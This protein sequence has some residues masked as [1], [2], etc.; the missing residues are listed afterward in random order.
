MAKAKTVAKLEKEFLAILIEKKD[1]FHRMFKED[2]MGI[3]AVVGNADLAGNMLPTGPKYKMHGMGCSVSWMEGKGIR[4]KKYAQAAGGAMM[5][6]RRKIEREL[7]RMYPNDKVIPPLH[8][9]ITVNEF[10]QHHAGI[11]FKENGVE[12]RCMSRLD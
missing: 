11:W 12:V 8:Q 6:F 4:G 9:D 1:A 10:F 7:V 2:V 5:D 3:V